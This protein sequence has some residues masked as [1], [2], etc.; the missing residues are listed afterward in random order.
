MPGVEYEYAIVILTEI[1]LTD[2]ADTNPSQF[3]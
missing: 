3:L 1:L 2:V